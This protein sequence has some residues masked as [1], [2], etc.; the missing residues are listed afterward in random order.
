ML[1]MHNEAQ[2]AQ[3][4]LRAGATGYLCKTCMPE[5]LLGAI[6]RAAS[7][8]RVIDPQIAEDIALEASSPTQQSHHS[9]LT[10]RELQVL[11]LFALGTSVSGIAEVLA[12][13]SKTVSTHKARLMEK[14]DFSSNADIVRYAVSQNLIV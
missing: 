4:M 1:S 2:I 14:M 8:A 9:K 5:F 6:R 13:S 3:R 11:R 7:G 12:I 10:E